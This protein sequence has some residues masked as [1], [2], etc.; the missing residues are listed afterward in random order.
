M[1]CTG[2]LSGCSETSDNSK[3]NI[4]TTL[5]STLSTATSTMA[6]H[7]R[8]LVVAHA[9]KLSGTLGGSTSTRP[10]VQK[11]TLK[12]CDFV[13]IGNTAIPTTLGVS[14]ATSPPIVVVILR[15]QLAYLYIVNYGRTDHAAPDRS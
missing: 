15:Q 1:V 10:G 3:K 2:E 4:S 9:C 14:T 5:S 13:D 11:I 12:I 6:C 8:G 7:A